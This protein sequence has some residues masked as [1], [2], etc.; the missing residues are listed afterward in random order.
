L[1]RFF[2]AK[3]IPMKTIL[4][5]GA[6][7]GLGAALAKEFA[8]NNTHL[9]LMGR[10]TTR[11]KKVAQQCET[12]NAKVTCKVID[13]TD[14]DAMA[15]EIEALDKK[16]SID[17][18]VANAGI[19]GGT[20]GGRETAVQ[21]RQIFDVNVNGVLN[22]VLPAIPCMINRKAGQIVIISSLAGFRGLSG[23]PAYSAS[24]NAVRA[25]GEALRLDLA[26]KGIKVN[27]VCPG[28]IK[29]PL[30]D[31]NKFKMP[32]LMDAEYAARVIKQ[33]IDKNKARIAFPF[34]LAA[35]TRLISILP[36]WLSDFIVSKL[37][38]K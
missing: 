14:S 20:A 10:D 34:R 24:K 18:V 23:A 16:Y 32:I 12:A 9:I 3:N 27:V 35:I 1:G 25:W 5:T 4:I 15:A 38:G 11:L 19:S 31:V 33:G 37:P 2:Y 8:D 29:T 13:V 7:S 26:T 6:S 30:T 22:T 17:M 28:F 36:L 21:T